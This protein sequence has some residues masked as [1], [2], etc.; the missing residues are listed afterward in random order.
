[1]RRFIF[2]AGPGIMVH[3]IV[4]ECPK[5]AEDLLTLVLV[6]ATTLVV[7]GGAWRTSMMGGAG[8]FQYPDF[9]LSGD[10]VTGVQGGKKS[11]I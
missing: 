5:S 2:L 8:K 9:L 1:M 7:D 11:K 3:H 6:N 10:L 4:L